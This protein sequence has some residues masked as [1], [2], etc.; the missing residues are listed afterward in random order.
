[1]NQA[2]TSWLGLKIQKTN[3]KAQK[4]DSTTMETYEIVVFTFFMLDKDDKKRF[5]EENFLLTDVKLDV[6]LKILFL[7]MSNTDIDFKLGTYNKNPIL[8]KTYF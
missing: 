3:A 5:F 8:L 2:F 6:V 4:I 7:T 1:M